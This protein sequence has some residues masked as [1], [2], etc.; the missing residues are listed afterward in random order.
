[1]TSTPTSPVLAI[2]ALSFS[3]PHRHVFTRWSAQL[4]PGLTWLKG[5][6]GCGK[7]T[8]L[9]LLAGALVPTHGRL[10]LQ[11]R[12]QPRQGQAF[13][14]QVFWC[15]PDRIAFDHLTPWEYWG[16]MRTLY[17]SFD[18]VR[19]RAMLPLLGLAPHVQRPLRELSTGTQRKVWVLAALCAGT[20]LTL[21]DEP[22][23]ALDAASLVCIRQALAECA[24]QALSGSPRAWLLTSHEDIGPAAPLAQ[25]LNLDAASGP[26]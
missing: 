8:L 1:M 6:N 7:S 19:L 25:V 18:E 4:M 13:R 12:H 16:F 26:A 22:L 17:P 5:S 15:G 23:N 9:K 3:Y 14:Q 20:A 10:L 11:G 2:E 21:L 24:Q